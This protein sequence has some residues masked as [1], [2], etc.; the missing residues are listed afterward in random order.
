M[1]ELRTEHTNRHISTKEHKHRSEAKRRRFLAT[2]N[3]ISE[4][5][6]TAGSLAYYTQ[7]D[8]FIFVLN[9][10]EMSKTTQNFSIPLWCKLPNP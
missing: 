2:E 1:F 10:Q 8:D 7:S 4:T 6:R 5:N 3:C 9:T